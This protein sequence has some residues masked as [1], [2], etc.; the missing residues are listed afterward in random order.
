MRTRTVAIGLIGVCLVVSGCAIRYP[1]VQLDDGWYEGKLE[2]GGFLPP[3]ELALMTND[4]DVGPSAVVLSL[5]VSRQEVDP[6]A[7]PP[8]EDWQEAD[9]GSTTIATRFYPLAKGPLRPYG[10]VGV[11]RTSLSADWIEYVGGGFDPLFRCIGFCDNTVDESGTIFSGF[12]TYVAAGVEVHPGFMAPSVL[13]E[14]RRD[15]VSDDDFYGLDG[16]RISVGLRLRW[17]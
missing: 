6:A 10:G 12:S 15:F 1:H 13:L 3:L 17:R 5:E 4:I 2:R 7:L 11:G 9:I 8:M 16:N 14:Y